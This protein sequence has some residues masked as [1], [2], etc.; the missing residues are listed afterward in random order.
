M[1]WNKI[2]KG[3]AAAGLPTLGA[4]LAGPAGARVGSVIARRLGAAEADPEVIAQ[5]LEADPEAMTE[6]RKIEAEMA[7]EEQAHIE[8]V[9]SSEQVATAA[10][11][12]R[13]KEARALTSG[14]WLTPWLSVGLLLI[15]ATF[16]AALFFVEPPQSNRDMVN[17]FLGALFGFAGAAVTYWLGSSRGSADRSTTIDQIAKRSR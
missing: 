14:H 11:Q 7:K 3:L 8:R 4:A 9:L 10:D 12:E 5:A 1:D 13:V 16:G 6:L 17:I 2:A 15:F